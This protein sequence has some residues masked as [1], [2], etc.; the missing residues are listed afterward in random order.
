MNELCVLMHKN[1]ELAVITIEDDDILNVQYNNDKNALSHLPVGYAK[2]LKKWLHS[3]TVPAARYAIQNKD[4]T[5]TPF[6]YMLSNYGL[7]LTDAYWIRPVKSNYTWKTI[8]LYTN[9]FKDTT[10]LELRS[11]IIAGVKGI[12]FTPS[13]TLNGDLR[14]KWLI[15]KNGQRIL[16][17]GNYSNSCI[18]AI[19]EVFATEIYKQQPYK[20]AYTPYEFI[21]LK[22][23]GK[24]ILGCACP[25]YTSENLEFVSAYDL[26]LEYKKPNNMNTFQFYKQLVYKLTGQNVDNYYDMML[27]TDFIITNTDRHFNNFGVLRNSDTLQ[28]VCPAPIYDS[29]N[30][31]FYK[32][33]YVPV[34]KA[35]LEIE[36][37]SF[38]SIEVEL[39]KEVKQR[40]L[41]DTKCL[42]TTDCLNNLLLKDELMPEQRR[43][44]IL[45]AYERKIEY[46]RDFQNGADLW[47]QEY[48]K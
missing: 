30:S 18:Q 47:K 6:R 14:K 20:V 46:L 28:Y 22:A 8:N 19:S 29:G 42:P 23:S 10:D 7:S 48:R 5:L 41:F 3:R 31:L 15:S 12:S 2:N 37:T 45:K 13:G 35:L 9:S 4:S 1:I 40:T 17:K 21:N 39:L 32:Q 25:A 38:K 44:R 24:E 36:V 34:G 33:D 43:E 26:L 16:V 11:S 27:M